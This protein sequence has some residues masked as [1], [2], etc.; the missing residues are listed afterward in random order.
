MLKNFLLASLLAASLAPLASCTRA[1]QPTTTTAA[2]PADAT[3]ADATAC[4]EAG[5]TVRTVTDVAG[6]VTFDKALQRY[7]I[8]AAEP[9][10][11]DVVNVG[12]VCGTLPEA[13][14]AEGTKVLFSGTYKA[15]PN[16]PAVPGGYTTYYLETSAV[17]VQ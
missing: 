12:V 16:P 2:T 10:T 17:K 13:L 8:L 7:K 11:A 5:G 14:R 3:P 6:S 15:Y 9:G 1:E 4:A